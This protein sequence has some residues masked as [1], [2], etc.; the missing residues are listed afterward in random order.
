HEVGG[1][2]KGLERK[3]LKAAEDAKNRLRRRRV[4]CPKVSV[5]DLGA[6]IA[7]DSPERRIVGG[8]PV[9]RDAFPCDSAVPEITPEVLGEIRCAKEERRAKERAAEKK[10]P[11]AGSR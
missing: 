4:D 8:I 2:K 9:W 10:E 1:G 11:A 3:G 7:G 6:Q 5:R